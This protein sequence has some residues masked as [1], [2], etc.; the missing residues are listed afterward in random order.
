[1]KNNN[2]SL[3]GKI[4]QSVLE[5][6]M[7][8]QE[9]TVTLNISEALPFIESSNWQSTRLFYIIGDQSLPIPPTSVS[10]RTTTWKIP[11]ATSANETD[12]SPNGK[13]NRGSLIAVKYDNDT[14]IVNGI[15]TNGGG[16]K[17]TN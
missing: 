2:D 1:M 17:Q 7:N 6:Y 8:K 13:F 14:I 15:T 5:F 10:T 12:Q 4:N 9:L 16:E 3:C 11:T